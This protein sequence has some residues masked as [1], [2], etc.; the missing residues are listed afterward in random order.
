MELKTK[1]KKK[2]FLALSAA[3]AVAIPINC[4]VGGHPVECTGAFKK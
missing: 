4:R 1:I 2:I 3:K